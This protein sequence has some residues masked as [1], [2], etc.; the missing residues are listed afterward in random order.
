MRR[1]DG[2][3]GIDIYHAGGVWLVAYLAGRSSGLLTQAGAGD[4]L[5]AASTLLMLAGV[6]WVMAMF[7]GR[8]RRRLATTQR[9]T[10]SMARAQWRWPASF[11]CSTRSVQFDGAMIAP[12]LSAAAQPPGLASAAMLA[13]SLLAVARCGG[14]AERRA[15]IVNGACVGYGW[16]FWSLP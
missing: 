7:A 5:I 1:N 9:R 13:A 12:V 2:K 10:W 14:D 4:T 16:L 15:D 11:T 8:R 3:P 6:V